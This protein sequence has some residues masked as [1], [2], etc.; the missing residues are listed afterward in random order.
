MSRDG[1]LD[2]GRRYLIQVVFVLLINRALDN[3]F[4]F[5]TSKPVN[6]RFPL[7]SWPSAR[8]C[9]QIVYLLIHETVN[10]NEVWQKMAELLLFLSNLSFF[11]IYIYKCC[12]FQCTWVFC[13]KLSPMHEGLGKFKQT[14]S[15]SHH[16]QFQLRLCCFFLI[17]G[18][19]FFIF[20]NIRLLPRV[21]HFTMAKGFITRSIC[22]FL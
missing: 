2:T 15:E 9:I 14:V 18:P 12:S 4:T 3:H 1:G 17:S 20:L 19:T 13:W 11:T 5:S 21:L 10:F 16:W 7:R 8:P 22:P 6:L